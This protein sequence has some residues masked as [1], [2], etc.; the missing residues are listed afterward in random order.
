MWKA[1]RLHRRRGG[2]YLRYRVLISLGYRNQGWESRWVW[3]QEEPPSAPARFLGAIGLRPRCSWRTELLPR[4]AALPAARCVEEPA[5]GT[6]VCLRVFGVCVRAS[7]SGGEHGSMHEKS[8]LCRVQETSGSVHKGT[9]CDLL[10]R[11]SR[12]ETLPGGS[13]GEP[14]GLSAAIPDPLPWLAHTCSFV[15]SARC[16]SLRQC[17][18]NSC[19]KGEGS[20]PVS[21]NPWPFFSAYQWTRI[22]RSHGGLIK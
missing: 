5:R 21:S 9:D 12:S 14:A 17:R 15:S 20:P 2:V 13:H 8:F 18:S 7:E 11:A 22:S 6:C 1:F 4:E 10:L 16:A 19:W 3:R